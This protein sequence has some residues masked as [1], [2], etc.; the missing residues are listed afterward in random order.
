[1]ARGD[2]PKLDPKSLPG[3]DSILRR[4]LANGITF[5]GRENFASPSVVISGFLQVGSLDED[6]EHTGL[7]ALTASCLMRGTASRSFAE[8]YESIESIGASL[9]L[10]AGKHHTSFPA[11]YLGGF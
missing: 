2:L 9:N 11:R 3:P 7:A 5:L 10:S 6:R 8:I 4:E 1:M